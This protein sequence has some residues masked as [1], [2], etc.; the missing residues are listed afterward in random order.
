MKININIGSII[1]TVI[2][3]SVVVSGIKKCKHGEL[4]QTIDEGINIVE[5]FIDKFDSAVTIEIN[6]EKIKEIVGDLG[7]TIDTNTIKTISK[8]IPKKDTTYDIGESIIVKKDSIIK[9]KENEKEFEREI[10][11][12]EPEF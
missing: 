8:I 5:E 12:A 2:I 4:E 1:W 6:K 9:P 3:I 7:I 11:W 10:E